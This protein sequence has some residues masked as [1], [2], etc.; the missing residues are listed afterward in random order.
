MNQKQ[1]YNTLLDF[2][3]IE[4]VSTDPKRFVQILGAISFLEKKLQGLGFEVKVLK[5]DDVPPLIVAKRKSLF[6]SAKTIGIYGHYD[7]QP[8]DPINEWQTP[9]FNLI[10]KNGKLYGRGVADNKGHI[11]QNI[12]AIETLVKNK[13]FKNNIVFILEG[14]EE[15]GSVHFEEYV[16][17]ARDVLRDVDVF[18]LTDMGLH[19]KNIAQIFYALRGIVTF[20]IKIQIGLR[21]LHSGL[22]GNH[23]LNPIQVASDLF[24][25]IKDCK[26]GKVLIP[27]FYDDVRKPTPKEI[28]L[29]TLTK[30]D[31]EDEKK[32]TGVFS[33]I[34]VDNEPAYLSSKIF[35]SFDLHGIIAG[36]NKPGIKTVI[37]HKIVAKFSCRLVENQ[38][39]ERVERL[40]KGFIKKNI[41]GGVKYVLQTFSK[42][43]PFYT[44]INNSYC[45]KTACIFTQVFGN[46]TLFNR[47]G[48][49]VGAAEVLQ[50][51]FHKPIILTGFTL[52]NDNIHAPNEN[53][54]ADMFWKG[55]KALEKIYSEI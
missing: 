15:I 55:I 30:R 28:E 39:P 44:D 34:S 33:L 2:I 36:Y 3:R 20:E 52:P 19:Q 37:P 1:I 7:V 51:V 14:E 13:K 21:D 47:S 8:E 22:Y 10:Q 45:Q 40:V 26:T 38:D 43:S 35:P 49:S 53:F 29:L 9:A 17:K 6:K 18:Y 23:V 4:S 12:A 46:K 11:I 42:S 50:R 48:G 24:N 54:D 41:I 25:R 32:E 31:A 5:K 16:K 27:H